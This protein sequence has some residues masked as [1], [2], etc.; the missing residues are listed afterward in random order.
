MNAELWDWQ[1]IKVLF[2]LLVTL[3]LLYDYE[4]WASGTSTTKWMQIERIKKCLI[5]N[6][7]KI[8]IITPYEII[9]IE[10]RMFPLEATTM[11]K[12]LYY[13]NKIEKIKNNRWLKVVR[14][15]ELS[16]HKNTWMK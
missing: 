8:K 1:T 2:S 4:V 10:T 7:L 14:D 3:I 12:M 11:T 9:L 15:E 6:S 5:I 13:L 16:K